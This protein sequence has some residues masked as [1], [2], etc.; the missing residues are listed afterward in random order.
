MSDSEEETTT[1]VTSL[2]TFD[3]KKDK[4]Q[5]YW[6]KFEGYANLNGFAAALEEG[7]EDILPDTD[8]EEVTDKKAKRARNR[9][10]KAVYALTMS[11]RKQRLMALVHKGKTE[12]YPKGLAHLIVKELKKKYAPKICLKSR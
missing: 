8:D 2:P 4:F 1:K 10:S 3:G 6:T 11:F 12:K 7:G 9:N 5:Q